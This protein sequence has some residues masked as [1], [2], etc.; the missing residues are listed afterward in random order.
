VRRY[1]TSIYVGKHNDQEVDFVV[2]LPDGGRRYYQV[3]WTVLDSQTLKRELKPLES[4]KDNY[5]KFVITIDPDTS[6]YE[7]IQKLNVTDWLLD[8]K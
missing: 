7:G 4:I 8:S 6:V 5:Q 1:G 3:A 2:S